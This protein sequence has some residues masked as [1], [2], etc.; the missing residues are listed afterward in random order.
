MSIRD[1][2]RTF[3]QFEHEE[4]WSSELTF[5]ALF[6]VE[7]EPWVMDSASA[8]AASNDEDDDDDDDFDDE[9]DDSVD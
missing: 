3:E 2:Y 5:G 1:T 8:K 4:L 7:E 6:E 9:E